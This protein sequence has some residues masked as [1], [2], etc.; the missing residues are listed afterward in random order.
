M[1]CPIKTLTSTCLMSAAS[2]YLIGAPLS[3]S[4]SHNKAQITLGS[5]SYSGLLRNHSCKAFHGQSDCF[6]LCVDTE[7][8]GINQTHQDSWMQD[9]VIYCFVYML[10]R[11][12][13]LQPSPAPLFE[14]IPS[15]VLMYCMVTSI[16]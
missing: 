15:R 13:P 5:A 2:K 12:P 11:T 4:P 3:R 7:M 8:L 6:V 14:E 16:I 9:F 1:L 10:H